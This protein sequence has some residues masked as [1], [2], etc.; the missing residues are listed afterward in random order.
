MSSKICKFRLLWFAIPIVQWFPTWGT[1][2]PRF[3]W[4]ILRGT[5][6]TSVRQNWTIQLHLL[7]K[8]SQRVREFLFCMLGGT[9]TQK[10]WEPLLKLSIN[11][12]CIIVLYCN[13]STYYQLTSWNTLEDETICDVQENTF[14]P[15]L[16]YTQWRHL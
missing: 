5:R 3:M 4:E 15:K 13:P 14:F 7:L 9:W 16:K 11:L 2:T 1:R 12:I 6:D 10:G 8:T